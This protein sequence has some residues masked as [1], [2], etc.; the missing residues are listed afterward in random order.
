MEQTTSG[1]SLQIQDLSF[2]NQPYN[3]SYHGK[4]NHH[5]I[6][7]GVS[8]VGEPAPRAQ[9]TG[10]VTALAKRGTKETYL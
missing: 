1:S 2:Q 10:Q 5:A 4:L 7:N 3:F 9:T 6:D 8:N